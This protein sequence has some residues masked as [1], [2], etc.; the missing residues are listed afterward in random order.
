[1]AKL[2]T[3]DIIF[4]VPTFDGNPIKCELIPLKQREAGRVFHTCVAQLFGAITAVLGETDQQKQIASIAAALGQIDYDLVWDVASAL[5]KDAVI[6]GKEIQ[7]LEEVDAISES[8]WILYMI[9]FHGVKGNWP[10]VFSG[11]G[12][13]L[14]GFG[15]QIMDQMGMANPE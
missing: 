4:E 6:G 2:P 1:M 7:S 11:L 10:R 14:N 12:A 9:I 5:C 8:P 15:S 3:T 13:K